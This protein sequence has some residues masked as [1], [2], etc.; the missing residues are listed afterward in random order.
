MR[1]SAAKYPSSQHGIALLI[2]VIVLAFASIS[3]TLGNI[4]VEQLRSEQAASTQ[5]ALQ[6]AKQALL[7]HAVTHYDR[8]PGEF[9]FLP[10]PD[11][12]DDTFT[13][14]GG[15]DGNCGTVQVNNLGLFPWASLETGIL[16]S[17]TGEC[18]WYGVSGEYK[19]SNNNPPM[20]NQDTN[21]AIRLYDSD[22][23]IRQGLQPQDRVVAV[24][25]DPSGLLPSQNGNRSF[26]D[27]S[28][29]GKDYSPARYLEGNGAINNAVLS[30]GVLDID[31]FIIRGPGTDELDTPFNDQMVF[32]TREELW[33][34]VRKRKD[35]VENTDS[36][37][38]R[39]TEALAWCIAEYGNN[40]INRKLP[41]PAAVD[42]GGLDYRKNI[43]YSDTATATY[44][45]RYPYTVIDSDK[46]INHANAP[47]PGVAR[48]FDKGFC[49][50]LTVNSGGPVVNLSSTGD[51]QTIWKNWKDHFFYAASSRY[52]PSTASAETS[53]PA[54][55]G[56]DC[57]GVDDASGT[58]KEY[59]AVVLFAG[60]R[61]GGQ[62]RNEPVAD[63][64]DTKNN[65][66]SYL[67]VANPIGD[68]TGDYT[69][70]GND[71]AFCI[72]DESTFR[73]VSCP[74]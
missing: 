15:G 63:G 12:K 62:I 42:F 13:V 69:P 18:L 19:H 41:R 45:G 6:R 21:G 40:T 47:N 2:F 7:D 66:D 20:L 37:M 36:T 59:A 22:G 58:R 30:G 32:I 35:F 16:R 10:C 53:W 60:E 71:I 27:T 3:Y 23:T 17:G 64:T 31:D 70:T 24:V 65:L 29:C 67:E 68:G 39:I 34:A 55:D 4:S 38:R 5:S 61:E 54:C 43:N 57:V 51:D 28:L 8:Y 25:I 9:G 1:H 49:S 44:V 46:D 74:E 73:A 11:Y 56:I 52:A 48:L 26:D 14:E 72:T 50:A 33:D